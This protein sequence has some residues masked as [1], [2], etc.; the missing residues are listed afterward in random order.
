MNKHEDQV[1]VCDF[2]GLKE[3]IQSEMASSFGP[4]MIPI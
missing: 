1:A 4:A 2:M 3:S